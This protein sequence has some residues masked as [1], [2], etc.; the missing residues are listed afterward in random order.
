MNRE[1]TTAKR[2]TITGDGETRSDVL[3]RPTKAKRHHETVR[4][5]TGSRPQEEQSEHC[6]FF[7]P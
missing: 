2:R 5:R 3:D 7:D 1:A 6:V 4:S